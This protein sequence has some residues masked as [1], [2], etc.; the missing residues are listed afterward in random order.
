VQVPVITAGATKA[1]LPGPVNMVVQKSGYL[2]VYVSNESNMNVYFDDVVVNHK[3]GPVLEI[4]N[5][6]AFGTE[7]GTLSGKSY[8]KLENKYRY[9]GKELQSKEFSDGSGLEEY[10]YGARLYDPQIGR[11][12]TIDPLSDKSRRW[13]PYNYALDNPI[14]YIDPDGMFASGWMDNSGG[15]PDIRPDYEKIHD[16]DEWRTQHGGMQYLAAGAGGSSKPDDW[17]HNTETGEV[18]YG[19]GTDGC[20]YSTGGGTKTVRLGENGKW[21]YVGAANEEPDAIKEVTTP[22][23]YITET[24]ATIMHVGEKMD[25]AAGIASKGLGAAARGM[26]IAGAL[27]SG[28]DAAIDINKNG[29]N[30]SNGLKAATSAIALGLLI[31]NPAGVTAILAVSAISLINEVI[32]ISHE[33]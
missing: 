5:Y 14:R 17:V 18:Y 27:L 28:V 20:T 9:N 2:Y 23:S 25:H 26:G 29:L 4:N 30:F 16:N 13:S 31:F 3:S 1:A 22:A 6:R 33:Y 32:H 7:I 21:G 8:G 24:G 10:D 15:L 19:D 12:F 11:W